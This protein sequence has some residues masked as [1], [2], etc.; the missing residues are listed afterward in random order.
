MANQKISE[1][2]SIALSGLV[3]SDV[4]TLV[5][6]SAQ[7]TK[8]I[9]WVSLKVPQLIGAKL[10]STVNSNGMDLTA[11][12]Y[13]AADTELYDVGGWHSST[14]AGVFIVPSVFSGMYVDVEMHVALFNGTADEYADLQLQYY[15]SSSAQVNLWIDPAQ[16]GLAFTGLTASA[17]GVKVTGGDF[18]TGLMLVETDMTVDVSTRSEFSIRVVGQ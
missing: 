1:L 6:T 5:D 4:F 3:D 17:K 9:E 7:E 14:S 13:W 16:T 8:K 15:D 12:V 11:G 18:F 10:K 2:N